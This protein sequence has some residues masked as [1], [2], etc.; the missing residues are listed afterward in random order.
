MA[1]DMTVEGLIELLKE[2]YPQAIVLIDEPFRYEGTPRVLTPIKLQSVSRTGCV[3]I[4]C[5]EDFG[6]R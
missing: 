4:I 3:H 2:E 6:R 1:N 5:K